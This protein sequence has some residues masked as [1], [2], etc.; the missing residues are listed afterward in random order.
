MA[1]S[2]KKS[3]EPKR[4]IPRKK[5][6]KHQ[7]ITKR[8][9]KKEPRVLD[10]SDPGTGKTRV[11][12]E[13]WA[14]RR[15]KGG[16]ALLI[17][18]PKTLL[19]SAWGNEIEEFISNYTYS[20]ARAT[21]R[22][23]AFKEAVDIYITNTDAVKWLANQKSSF[24]RPFDTLVID[25]ITAFKHRTSQRAKAAKSIAKYFKYRS[26]LTGTPN[27]L[28]I[29]DLWHQAYIIDDGHR[30]GDN[31]FKFR[32]ATQSATQVGPHKSMIKWDDKPG[33]EFAVA[34]LLQDIT[35]RHKFEECMDIPPNHTQE[36]Q[37]FLPKKLKEK[38]D[39]LERTTILR[40]KK[41]KVDAVNAAV[42]L[43]KL[44]QLASGAVY[45]SEG[46]YEVIDDARY[47]LIS[48]LIE[49]RQHSICFYNWKHQKEQLLRYAN[50]RGIEHEFIDGTVPDKRRET[51]VAAYQEG[52]FQTLYLHPQTGA[53]G[54][55]LTKGTATIWSSPIYQADFL[56]QGLHRIF[57]GGQTQKTETLLIKAVGTVE[58]SVYDRLNVKTTRMVNLLEML[59]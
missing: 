17:I 43:N 46:K 36:I 47:D 35:V 16:G 31:F 49:A 25:E 50:K 8:L 1:S 33:A 40:L 53:H 56:K 12:L 58:Q 38:Y 24:F 9:L 51:I 30:L 54:L 11:H 42:L 21:N 20:I 45:T 57:R 34:G 44:L 22:I 2:V 19:Q 29:T 55:T 10:L 15:K 48:D 23:E 18:A 7:A 3:A 39:K 4:L 52:A 27:P 37:Y 32:N 41:D 28:S 59:E 14:E 13:A 6:W 26:G 5:L